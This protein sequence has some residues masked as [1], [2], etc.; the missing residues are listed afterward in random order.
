MANTLGIIGGGPTG[1]ASALYLARAGNSV[2]LYEKKNW[3]VDKVCGE[4]IMPRGRSLLEELGLFEN[5]NDQDYTFFKGIRYIGSRGKV[6]EGRF[7]SLEGLGIRRTILSQSLLDLA[8]KNDRIKLHCETK[9]LGLNNSK[10]EIELKISGNIIKSHPFVLGCDGIS[11]NI[12]SWEK[13][14]MRDFPY[15]RMGGRFHV[16]CEPWTPFVEVYWGKNIEAYITP[17][18]KKM[19]E[20]AFLWSPKKIKKDR[21][22]KWE[23]Y[24]LK[25]FPAIQEKIQNLPRLSKFKALGPLARAAK[26]PC[27]GNLCLLGDSFLFLDGITGEGITLGLEQAKL[28]SQ[29]YRNGSFNRKEYEKGLGSLVRNYL[30][31]T[32]LALSLSDNPRL[33]ETLFMVSPRSLLKYFI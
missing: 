2:E 28:F 22:E 25:Q 1:L 7:K 4:G 3:P 5:L 10:E 16:E 26:N 8:K 31:L 11:S 18:G 30:R 17:S 23:E 24:L 15:F 14:P 27:S 29:H 20:V 21:E 33:R 32:K 12:R 13:F 6:I 9:I 19:V